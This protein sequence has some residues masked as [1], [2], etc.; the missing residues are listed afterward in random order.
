MAR[1]QSSPQAWSIYLRLH[2]AIQN[3]QP[4]TP[5]AVAR[6]DEAVRAG[7]QVGSSRRQRL[8]QA[9]DGIPALL[10][11]T[12]ILGG[13][14][15]VGFA[16]LFGMKSTVTHALVMFSLTLLIGGLLLVI[17]EMNFPFSGIRVGPE[18]F[19]LALERMRQVP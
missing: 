4:A 19:E 8:N 16:F 14:I 13:A 10:W 2:E 9:A 11:A 7:D 17:Y 18:S 1:Q 3:Q 12:L 15:T 5:A 6:Y